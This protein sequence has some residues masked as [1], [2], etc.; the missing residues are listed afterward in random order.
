LNLEAR[1]KTIAL[2]AIYDGCNLQEIGDRFG[3]SRERVRQILLDSAIDYRVIR[4]RRANQERLYQEALAAA[5]ADRAA[6]VTPDGKR[7]PEYNV[8][9]LMLQ[10]CF[11][12]N[13]PGFGR[14]GGRELPITVCERWLGKDGFQNFCKDMGTRPEGKYASGRAIYSIHRVNDGNYEPGIL[15]RS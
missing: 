13:N 7:R 1:N 6:T 5:K 11:N 12:R 10:R 2:M 9:R 14:Y 3:L 4:A 8:Y 15:I